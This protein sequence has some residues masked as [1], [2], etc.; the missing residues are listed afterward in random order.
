MVTFSFRFWL[1]W[2]FLFALIYVK[3]IN[4]YHICTWLNAI[5][6]ISLAP[7]ID[8]ATITQLTN[9]VYALIF[10]IDIGLTH[11]RQLFEV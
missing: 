3:Q 5:V 8:A 6:F 1:G 10:T 7:E 11:M 2:Y 9:A 4:N